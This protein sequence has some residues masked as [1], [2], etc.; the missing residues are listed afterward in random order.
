[1]C[2]AKVTA[3]ASVCLRACACVCVI[4]IAEM[5][6]R[7]WLSYVLTYSTRIYGFATLWTRLHMHMNTC[8]YTYI[9]THVST[10]LVHVL[11]S[12][13]CA[14]SVSM[15]T[16]AR[17]ERV[18]NSSIPAWSVSRCGRGLYIHG[19]THTISMSGRQNPPIWRHRPAW[20]RHR[21]HKCFA[22]LPKN[23]PISASRPVV[24][25]QSGRHTHKSTRPPPHMTSLAGRRRSVCG[26]GVVCES[27]RS[28]LC[29]VVSSPNG[30]FSR[31]CLCRRYL[32]WLCRTWSSKS[33]A[34]HPLRARFCRYTGVC[35][36]VC[37]LVDENN[38][39]THP[40]ADRRTTTGTKPL[41]FAPPNVLLCVRYRFG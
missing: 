8:M 35:V 19:I 13:N 6:V 28:C 16:S 40:A 21:R 1:M 27:V 26:G 38:T 31:V 22:R 33:G 7:T 3:S 23:G 9:H 36:C 2:V 32:F 20:W 29:C 17:I 39:R 34:M 12:G 15:V 11:R 18:R 14:R 25:N 37:A 10:S 5:Y 30:L 24:V 4:L 41:T